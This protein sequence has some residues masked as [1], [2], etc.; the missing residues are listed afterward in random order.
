MSSCKRKQLL[1]DRPLQGRLMARLWLYVLLYAFFVIHVHFLMQLS[2]QAIKNGTQ[3]GL[4]GMYVDFLCTQSYV[5]LSVAILAPCVLVDS[6][7]FS[8]RIAGPLFRCRTMIYEMAAGK[9][10][11]EFTP[12][13]G[14][15][16]P[17]FWQAFNALIRLWNARAGQPQQQTS[18][19]EPAS[20]DNEQ[21]ARTNKL[22]RQAVNVS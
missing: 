7:K 12:R 1:V 4:F 18:H 3:N 9:A 10:V 16:M 8:N 21:P 15:L 11:P 22:G 2:H 5:L 20:D 6:L 19:Q 14:D 17:E 13:K